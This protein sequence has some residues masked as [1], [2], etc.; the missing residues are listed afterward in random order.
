MGRTHLALA[1]L[2]HAQGHRDAATE[3]A[4]HA[5]TL[6]IALNTPRYVERTQQFASTCGLVLST[7][8]ALHPE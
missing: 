6:F 8:D 4:N 2:A 3:H 1:E 7:A 5:Q